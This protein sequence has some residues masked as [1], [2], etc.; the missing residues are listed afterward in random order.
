MLVLH[1]QIGSKVYLTLNDGSKAVVT[2]LSVGLDGAKVGYSAPQSV[3][4]L[5]DKL[6]VSN[7]SGQ[8]RKRRSNTGTDRQ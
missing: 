4:I 5:R 6:E 2:L 3:K 1:M 7:Q 8:N